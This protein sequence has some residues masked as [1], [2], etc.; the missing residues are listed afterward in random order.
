MNKR[1]N[2]S[3][4]LSLCMI[5]KNEEQML[6]KCLASIKG[7]V[8]EIVI[9][10][11][12]STDG[13]R[14][15][16]ADYNIAWF[17]R[18]W[19]DDFSAARNY[20]IEK[21]SGDWVLV[22]DAD[23]TVTGENARRIRDLVET[24]GAAAYYLNFRSVVRESAAGNVLIHSHARLFI[25]FSFKEM[26]R[27]IINHFMR[28][29]HTG[30]NALWRIGGIGDKIN[31]LFTVSDYFITVFFFKSD[32]KQQKKSVDESHFA[33]FKR[34]QHIFRVI[35]LV[36][37]QQPV[38]EYNRGPYKGVYPDFVNRV[39]QNFTSSFN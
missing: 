14:E 17:S 30:R 35:F 32:T 20:S 15:A 9:V 11:T 7:I 3:V 39:H 25:P 13:T 38:C 24:G 4:R 12:G 27:K 21:A 33:L 29:L 8:D 37:L 31:E 26:S 34:K 28:I 6:P 23:E 19:D 16:A 10:D 5:V 2:T 18:T 1:P 36:D 22:L